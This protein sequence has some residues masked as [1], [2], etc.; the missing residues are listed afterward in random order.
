MIDAAKAKYKKPVKYLILSHHHWDHTNGA[1]TFVAEG[2]TVI[3]G[4][5]NKDYFA[6]MFSARNTAAVDELERKPRKATIIEVTDKHILSDGKR[7]VGAYYIEH[8]H[9][10]G[11]LIGYIPDARDIERFAAGHGSTGVFRDLVAIVEKTAP[12]S[13]AAPGRL[14]AGARP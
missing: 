11:T 4:K 8:S 7:Q 14:A 10:N 13:N 1:R 5:G 3:V 9:S 6:K 2:A 12:R